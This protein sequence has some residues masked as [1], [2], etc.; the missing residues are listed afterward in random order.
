MTNTNQQS[1]CILHTSSSPA[2]KI[3]QNSPYTPHTHTH[4]PTCSFSKMQDG[5]VILDLINDITTGH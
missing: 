4:T 5:I 2:T 1:V 3:D